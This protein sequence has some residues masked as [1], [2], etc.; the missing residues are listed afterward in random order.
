M[1]CPPVAGR[2]PTVDGKLSQAAYL[3]AVD[4]CYA[5][6]QA[7]LSAATGGGV[8]S[9]LD[10]FD[11]ACLHSPYNKL[12]QKGFGRMLNADLIA[13]PTSAEWAADE[14]AQRLACQLAADTVD[15]REAEKVLRRLSASRYDAMCAA[16][17]TLSKAVGNCYTAALY[18]NLLSLVSN[19]AHSLPGK[20]VLMFSYGSGAVATAF[21]INCRAPTAHNSHDVRGEPFTLERIASVADISARLSAC[22]ERSVAAFSEA[23]DLRS[24]RYGACNYQ[25]SGPV[26]DLWPGTFY[27]TNIDGEHRRSYS[28]TPN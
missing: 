1:T 24:S 3:T 19:R 8:P 12:V 28:R 17:H 13:S 27:L 18:M 16:G 23:M 9:S 5:G 14:E 10:S 15:D 22:T 26:A 2:Y 6:L 25:P 4:K 20:R 11:Y 7:K 21:T